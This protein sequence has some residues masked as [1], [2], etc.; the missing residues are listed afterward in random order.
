[1]P[2]QESQ[3]SLV[4][5][6]SKTQED[7]IALSFTLPLTCSMEFLGSRFFQKIAHPFT[8]PIA[9]AS[10]P[11]N[12]PVSACIQAQTCI[13]IQLQTEKLRTL[14]A[15]IDLLR[16][17]LPQILPWPHVMSL[18]SSCNHPRFSIVNTWYVESQ[19]G[20]NDSQLT[21]FYWDS[22]SGMF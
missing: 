21:Q 14:T 10:L 4:P 11:L 3:R 9:H 13:S 18:H 8:L 12:L 19:R 7:G 15:E 17:K 5:W 16:N 2:F 1:V 20:C 22:T 6:R